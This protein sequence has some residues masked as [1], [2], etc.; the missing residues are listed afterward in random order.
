M[1]TVESFRQLLRPLI[2]YSKGVG[3]EIWTAPGKFVPASYYLSLH[4][5][6]YFSS[7]VFTLMKYSEDTLHMMKALITLGTCVQV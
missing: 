7:T 2:F 5:A 4:V 6:I 3:V 1:A